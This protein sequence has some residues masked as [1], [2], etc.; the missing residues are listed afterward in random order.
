V[1][2]RA[3]LISFAIGLAAGGAIALAACEEGPPGG[4]GGQS[5]SAGGGGGACPDGPQPMFTISISAA[6][7][8]VPPDTSLAVTWSAGSE[9]LFVLSDS[10]TWATLEDGANVVC[11]VDPKDPPSGPLE[12]LVCRLWTSGPTEIVVAAQS[13]QNH[14]ETLVPTMS[15]RCDG[16]LPEDVAVTLYRQLD[17][18]PP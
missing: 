12:A 7:G 17:G 18:G 2:G 11:N 1:V 14:T 8:P 13:Y 15:E 3:L 10:S 9:P 4:A 6:D 5:G 16:P